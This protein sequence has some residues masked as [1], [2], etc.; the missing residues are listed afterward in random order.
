MNNKQIVEKL[1]A[2]V[3]KHARVQNAHFDVCYYCNVKTNQELELG[4]HKIDCP[5]LIAA[6]VLQNLGH[7]ISP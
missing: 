5:V 4:E 3:L 2:Q 6:V 7:E 1:S